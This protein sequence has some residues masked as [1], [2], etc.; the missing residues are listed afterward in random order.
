[1]PSLVATA[2]ISA[3][4]AAGAGVGL[5][6][7][8]ADALLLEI[9]LPE[10]ELPETKVRTGV[11]AAR[12]RGALTRG[13]ASLGVNLEAVN[14]DTVNL[15]T[16]WEGERPAASAQDATNRAAGPGHV[17]SVRHR[18]A[19]LDAITITDRLPAISRSFFPANPSQSISGRR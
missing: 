5:K 11:R 4:G 7:E 16:T 19:V 9:E 17:F 10:I 2:V 12:I 18:L 6:V 8:T 1:M 3:D 15:E 14:L 13:A